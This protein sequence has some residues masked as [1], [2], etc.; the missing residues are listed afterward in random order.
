MPIKWCPN[1]RSDIQPPPLNPTTSFAKFCRNVCY[2][3]DS[4]LRP[5]RES[6]RSAHPTSAAMESPPVVPQSRP[7]PA[8]DSARK[9]EVDRLR[10]EYETKRAEV[11]SLRFEYERRQRSIPA[12]QTKVVTL[13][14][15]YKALIDLDDALN[16]SDQHNDNGDALTRA[17]ATVD[18]I[19]ACEREI[20]TAEAEMKDIHQTLENAE[21]EMRNIH[22]AVDN[23]R[24]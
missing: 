4:P 24:S 15:K 13:E 21:R 1:C 2:I 12:L 20:S 5:I 23:K 6:S 14:H 3:C 16:K 8:H 18:E 10:F 11:D 7:T 22:I 17:F 19:N 9:A